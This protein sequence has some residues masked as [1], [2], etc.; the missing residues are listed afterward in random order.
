M[1][2]QICFNR[3]IAI[4]ICNPFFFFASEESANSACA[5]TLGFARIHF[6]TGVRSN[7]KVEVCLPGE[8]QKH[9]VY[10]RL[11]RASPRTL[12]TAARV[13]TVTGP[14]P[15]PPLTPGSSPPPPPEMMMCCLMVLDTVTS[16][17]QWIRQPRPRVYL[18]EGTYP[19]MIRGCLE[20]LALMI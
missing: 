5:K 12:R 8:P 14:P 1:R 11:I 3:K 10:Y 18:K 15:C 13:R 9:I 20:G 7:K 2:N 4:Q 17:P 16:T 6:T 19:V